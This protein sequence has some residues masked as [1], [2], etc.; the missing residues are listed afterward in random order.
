[1]VGPGELSGLSGIV[2]LSGKLRWFL[3]L[4][5][6]IGQLSADGNGSTVKAPAWQVFTVSPQGLSPG[7][8]LKVR[9]LGE[10][11]H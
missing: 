8:G 3:G 11:T 9:L 10:G 2:V 1:M 7:P 4:A 5:D 6:C